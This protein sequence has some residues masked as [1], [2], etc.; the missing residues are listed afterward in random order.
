MNG[1]WRV[2]V[3]GPPRETQPRSY[4]PIQRNSTA[5]ARSKTSNW[6]PKAPTVQFDNHKQVLLKQEYKQGMIINAP[7]HEPMNTTSMSRA[8]TLHESISA[9]GGVFTKS[10]Y[11]I[12]IAKHEASYKCIPLYSHNREGLKGKEHYKDEFVSVRDHRIGGKFEA[13][14]NLKPLVTEQ[15]T[16]PVID[17]LSTA[18]LTHTVVRSYDLDCN[19]CGQLTQQSVRNLVAYYKAE[20]HRGLEGF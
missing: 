2:K 20:A 15:M 4:A 12:V 1:N 17:K 18:W 19:V 10:R 14:S 7:V 11:L 16:G 5:I 6:N 13:Q 9:Y 3:A 8:P